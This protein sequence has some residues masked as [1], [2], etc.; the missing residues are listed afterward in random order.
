MLMKNNVFTVIFAFTVSIITSIA[1]IQAPATNAEIVKEKYLIDC[2]N[3]IKEVAIFKTYINK[4]DKNNMQTQFLKMRFAYKK[5]ETIVEYFY[6]AYALKLN[7]PPIPFFEE[8]EA[9]VPIN[10]PFGM[11]VIEGIIYGDLN[12]KSITKAGTFRKIF[13]LAVLA[14]TT[15]FV[16][17]QDVD[18]IRNLAYLNQ[19]VKAKEAVD[20]YG[21]DM[22]VK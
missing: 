7:G 6:N 21:V 8:D 20:K 14:G 12:D 18:E 3:F 19:N 16:M 10:Q 17:A 4:D 15:G 11:Q 5:M 2:K 1:F 22:R 9:D 13:L